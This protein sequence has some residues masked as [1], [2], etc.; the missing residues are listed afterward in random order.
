MNEEYSGAEISRDGFYGRWFFVFM[1]EVLEDFLKKAL[2]L[3][4]QKGHISAMA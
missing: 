3:K 4:E 1:C 2:S